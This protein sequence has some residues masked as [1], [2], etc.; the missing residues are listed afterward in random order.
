MEESSVRFWH[1]LM[2]RHNGPLSSR[3]ILQ[4]L[5]EN[6]VSISSMPA[7]DV[8][9]MSFD[10]GR[11]TLDVRGSGSFIILGVIPQSAQI[12][13]RDARLPGGVK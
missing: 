11:H 6:A 8:H 1:E 5:I 3:L 9:A 7:I 12:T 4:P 10:K 13:K 2:A